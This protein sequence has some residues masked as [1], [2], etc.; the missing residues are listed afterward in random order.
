MDQPAPQSTATPPRDVLLEALADP[1]VRLRLAE[2]LGKLGH[3]EEARH[4][5]ERARVLRREAPPQ[6]TP[7]PAR[8]E[9]GTE[10]AAAA[11]PPAQGG[12]R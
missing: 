1:A 12:R 3:H 5:A 10:P 9:A 4:A 6:E 8:D 7:A 2:V 11:T